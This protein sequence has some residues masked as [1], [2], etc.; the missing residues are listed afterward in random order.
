[1][2]SYLIVHLNRNT[3]T[4]L[5]GNSKHNIYNSKYI[6]LTFERNILLCCY[7]VMMN[8]WRKCGAKFGI[9]TAAFLPKSVYKSWYYIFKDYQ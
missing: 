8:M 9:I 4:N 7:L 2:I 3:G 6:N 5:G 1:M